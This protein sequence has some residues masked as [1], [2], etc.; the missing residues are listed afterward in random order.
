MRHI[1]KIAFGLLFIFLLAACSEKKNSSIDEVIIPDPRKDMT[2]VRSSKDTAEIMKLADDFLQS[3][4]NK[5]VDGAL[6]QLYTVEH[7]TAKQLTAERRIKLEKM[8]SAIPVEDYK[9]DQVFLYSDSDT[10]VRYSV[11]M[12]KKPQGSKQPNTIKGALFP[13]RVNGTWFLTISEEKVESNFED[14]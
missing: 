11:E 4:K 8:F 5:D 3:L 1:L 7:N 9:I 2:M 14:N 10:E 12:F 13:C 6:K